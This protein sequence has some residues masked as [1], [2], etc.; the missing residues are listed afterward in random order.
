M[1]CSGIGLYLE[2]DFFSIMLGNVMEKKNYIINLISLLGKRFI[3]IASN[4]EFLNVHRFKS[5]V[6]YQFI[7][8]GFITDEQYHME[9]WRKF[10]EAEGW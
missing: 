5:F 7:L 2:L 8:E 3:Y 4:T 6:K 1:M 10:I 9:R